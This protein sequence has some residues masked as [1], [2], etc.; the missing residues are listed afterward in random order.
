MNNTK[1]A[2]FETPSG[3]YCISAIHR[4][5]RQALIFIEDLIREY[6][7]PAAEGHLLSFVNLYGPNSVGE[8]VR[9]FGYRKPTMSSMIN[10]LERKGLLRRILST[11]DR[12]SLIVELTP[13][14]RKLA[15]ACT[16]KVQGLDAAIMEQVSQAD[17]VGFQNVLRA[18]AQITG[19][20]VQKRPPRR[21]VRKPR[22]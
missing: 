20:E 22:P 13:E 5:N 16:A 19:V 14:G 2:Q 4:A 18:I 6:D 7:T 1:T 15:E 9:V 12:R 8:L 11:D 10:K 3:V 17:L 21:Q